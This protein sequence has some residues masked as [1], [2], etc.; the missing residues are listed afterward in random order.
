MVATTC[1]LWPKLA[2]RA[3]QSSTVRRSTIEQLIEEYRMAK[4]GRPLER[5][6][7]KGERHARAWGLASLALGL[8]CVIRVG[9]GGYL[10]P[11]QQPSVAEDHGQQRIV[12]LQAAVVFDEPQPSK[13]VHEEVDP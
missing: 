13:L 5:A 4:Q 6:I 11:S 7:R 12:D 2:V 1:E 9:D 10:S 8:M 3:V